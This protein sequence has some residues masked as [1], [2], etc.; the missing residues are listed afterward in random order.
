[1]ISLE[2]ILLI[3][4]YYFVDWLF[5]DGDRSRCYH[6][7]NVKISAGDRAGAAAVYPKV[8]QDIKS[9]LDEKKR[10]LDL[11]LRTKNLSPSFSRNTGGNTT[12]SRTKRAAEFC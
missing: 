10:C 1:M 7:Y 6:E 4:K 12:P 9:V 11:L 3:M 5:I 2:F 8:R